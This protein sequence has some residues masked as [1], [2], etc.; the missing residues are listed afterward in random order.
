MEGRVWVLV[1]EDP[2]E[3]QEPVFVDVFAS[4][5]GA[6]T[7]Y[8]ASVAEWAPALQ[9]RGMVQGA[10]F[11]ADPWNEAN[12]AEALIPA[13]R[14]TDYTLDEDGLPKRRHAAPTDELRYVEAIRLRAYPVDVKP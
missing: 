14:P 4:P 9:P 10:R 7:R 13:G 12:D 3:P 2:T 6:R 1:M 11:Y 5:T 8:E